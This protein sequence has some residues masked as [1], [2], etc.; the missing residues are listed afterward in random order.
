MNQLNFQVNLM[1]SQNWEPLLLKVRPTRSLKK[2]GPRKMI[3][4]SVSRDIHWAYPLG[5]LGSLLQE[6]PVSLQIG[7]LRTLSFMS[8]PC[9][10]RQVRNIGDRDV[11]TQ[12]T[13]FIVMLLDRNT[14]V[15]RLP[16]NIFPIPSMEDIV[17]TPCFR[18]PITLKLQF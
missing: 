3:I 13:V 17:W 1:S 10:S 2:Q 12:L 15:E 6:W 9:L 16:L 14:E 11:T 5:R 18:C 4:Y 8:Q 7:F